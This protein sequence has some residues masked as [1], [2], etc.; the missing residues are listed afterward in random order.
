MMGFT[1]RIGDAG[2]KGR[3][4]RLNLR[5]KGWWWVNNGVVGSAHPTKLKPTP[6]GYSRP[7]VTIGPLCKIFLQKIFVFIDEAGA[8][9]A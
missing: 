5:G 7:N 1:E 6:N 2:V 8:N 9:L 4:Q 3:R